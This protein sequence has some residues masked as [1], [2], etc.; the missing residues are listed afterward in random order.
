MPQRILLVVI[1][2][3][4]LVLCFSAVS[5]QDPNLLKDGGFESQTYKNVAIGDGGASF[6]V[7]GDW[8]G[9]YTQSPREY[10]WKNLTPNGAPH[11]GGFKK[12]GDRSLS[13]GRG[14]ATF[15]AAVYQQVTVT[16]G[17]N[18]RATAS[19]FI[20]NV[21]ERL[22]EVRIGIDPSG[23]TN[24][25]AGG[26]IWSAPNRTVQ[27][28]TSVSV[29]AT[30]TGGA[31]TVFLF[32][33]QLWPN[34]PNNVYWDDASLL[35]GG[36]GGSAAATAGPGTAVPPTSAPLVAIAPFV[37]A[38][39]PQPDGSIVHT[40]QSGDTI[41]SIA[42]AYGVTRADILALN[43]LDAR[44]FLI[45][46]QKLTIKQAPPNSI[47]GNDDGGSGGGDPEDTDEPVAEDVAVAAPTS[48]SDT[49]EPTAEPTNAIPTNTPEPTFTP[50]I[51]P[52][53]PVVAAAAGSVNPASTSTT[54]CVLLF[55]D[56]NANRIQE[57]G[58]VALPGGKL[59]LRLNNGNE[60]DSQESNSA[61]DL[62]CFEDLAAG[63]YIAAAEAPQGYGLTT[64]NQLRLRVQT[65]TTLSIAFGA[66]AGITSSV[67]P[68]PDAA[69]INQTITEETAETPSNTD[70]LLQISGLIVFGL[71]GLALVAGLG[72]TFFLRRR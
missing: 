57:E 53:A 63:E 54:V 70:Q 26:I 50:T 56:A 7:P 23:G 48:S 27:S 35:V 2:S 13:I 44:S 60:I 21:S 67:P 38:Q 46:G 1:C 16:A 42:V 62:Q 6:N 33:S 12:T 11:T 72:M 18:L 43:G 20:E 8:N 58:E 49:T 52:T 29:D 37:A 66:A 41:D 68:T 24:P 22:S 55:E 30:A 17:S 36:G 59:S 28:W 51:V 69:V 45:I 65:G 14:S 34:D 3:A 40:V 64:P 5:A 9:W 25:L 71:A 15:T 61:D 32:M 47:S 10:D 4:L 19:V 39:G 31:V